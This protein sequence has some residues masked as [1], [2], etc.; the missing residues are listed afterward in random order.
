MV[1]AVVVLV[2]LVAAGVLLY[3]SWSTAQGRHARW[4]V[5]SNAMEVLDYDADR[6]LLVDGTDMMLVDRAS[7]A[8]EL[9]W[10]APRGSRA[11]LVPGGVAF[12]SSTGTLS[13]RVDD[14]DWV[15]QGLEEKYTLVAVRDDVVVADVAVGLKHTLTGFA[16]T[17]GAP[18]WTMA[19]LTRIGFVDMGEEP[20]RPPGALRTTRLIP[21]MRMGVDGWSLLDAATG[22]VVATTPPSDTVPVATGDVAVPASLTR[23]AAL[24]IFAAPDRTVDWPEPPDAKCTVA[25]A[26]DGQR[27]LLVAPREGAHLIGGD[28]PVR[29]FSLAVDT[30]RV[31]ELDWHGTYADVNL[32]DGAQEITHSWGRYLFT[33]GTVYDTH[34]GKPG[35]QAEA[36]WLNGDTAVVAEPVAGLDRVGAGADD[37]SRWLRLTDAKTGEP[38]GDEY[39]TDLPTTVAVLDHGQALVMAGDEM[40]LLAR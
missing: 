5:E 25:W 27:V 37:D 29:L 2:L 34:T 18:V 30:G 12:S 7:G 22:A 19:N 8:T 1:P 35:W 20:P 21:V 14:K 40:A 16:L 36:A 13:A 10:F 32:G 28:Q 24:A 38:T 4:V 33:N 23:C 31:T 39:I 9:S 11:V 3:P 15:K 6:L 26:F 17:D